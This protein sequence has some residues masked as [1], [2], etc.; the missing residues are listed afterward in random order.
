MMKTLRKRLILFL[1][2]AWFLPDC[3]TSNKTQKG[4]AAEIGPAGGNSQHHKSKDAS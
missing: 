2:V 1:S 3:F 4:G